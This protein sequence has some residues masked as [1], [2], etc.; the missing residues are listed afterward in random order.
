MSIKIIP[1]NH[2]DL[3]IPEF[4]CDADLNPELKKIPSLSHLNRYTTNL[5]LGRPASGKTSLLISFLTNKGKNA[6]LRKIYNNVIVVMP[7]SSRDSLKNNIF[8][9]H[10]SDKLFED[11][12]GKNMETIYNMVVENRENDE[13]TLILYDDVG[14]QLKNKEIQ[15]YLKRLSMNRRHMKCTQFFLLQSY[16][17]LVK[18]IRKLFTNYII[19][20]L[21]KPEMENIITEVI[22]QPKD[23]ALKLLQL[24]TEPHQYLFINGPTQETYF[25]FDKV[26]IISP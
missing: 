8:E 11:L 5:I 22:E 15:Y 9:K 4:I 26:E 20:K 21:S 12:S 25:G 19:F 13:S 7:K 10:P 3:N 1:Q 6:V 16:M 2:I 14:S 17:S 24:Y 23:I 18:E